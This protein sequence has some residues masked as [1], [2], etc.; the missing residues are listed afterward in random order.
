MAIP[1]VRQL[2]AGLLLLGLA[3]G[4]E[5]VVTAEL[6]AANFAKEGD[7]VE[8]A[9]RHLYTALRALEQVGDEAKREELRAAILAAKN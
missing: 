8:A 2:A 5:D 9:A 1:S 3:A 7:R 4:Q 6:E